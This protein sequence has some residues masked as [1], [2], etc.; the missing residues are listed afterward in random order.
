MLKHD[1]YVR[2]IERAN[3]LNQ[4]NRLPKRDVRSVS[5]ASSPKRT[6]QAKRHKVPPCSDALSY[7]SEAE[8]MERTG[9]SRE[10]IWCMVRE[11]S[12]PHPAKLGGDRRGKWIP[13]QIEEWEKSARE[14]K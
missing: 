5:E 9:L 6:E 11:R 10:E 3:E 14:G 7:L 2:V 4:K 12:F 1:V 8:V 13:G